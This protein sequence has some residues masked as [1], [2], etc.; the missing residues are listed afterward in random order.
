MGARFL[1]VRKVKQR[2]KM[3]VTGLESETLESELMFRLIN[4]QM[5]R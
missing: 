5:D 2:G 1:I 4:M 3:N